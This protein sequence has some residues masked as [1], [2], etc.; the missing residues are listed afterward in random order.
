MTMAK[1]KNPAAAAVPA[2]AVRL[3]DR[4]QAGLRALRAVPLPD[5]RAV[6]IVHGLTSGGDFLDPVAAV[7]R[8]VADLLA[9]PDGDPRV[10]RFGGDLVFE[11]REDGDQRTLAPLRT[12]TTVERYAGGLLGN[13]LVC[14][15]QLK[16]GP[17]QFAAPPKALGVL[18]ADET[19]L[20]RLP[21]IDAYARRPVF[22]PD[23]VLLAPGYHLAHRILVHGPEVEPDLTPLPAGGRAIDRLPDRLRTLLADFCFKADADLVNAVG[24][25][26]TGLLAGHFVETGKPLALIDGNQPGVG[27]TLLVRVAGVLLDGRDPR[28][29]HFTANDEELAKR[30]CATL[31][32]GQQ[33]VL[34]IDNCKLA[35]GQ[36]VSSPALEANSM[37][38]EISLRILGVSANFVRPNDVL[39][40]LT[41]NSTRTSPDLVSRGIPIRLSYEGRPG[42]RR[43]SVADPVAYAR[44]HR[45]A[46]LGELAGFVERWAQAGRPPGTRPHRCHVWAQVIGGILAANGQPDFLANSAEA[47]D[48]FDAA[49]DELAA[50]A[51]AVLRTP[52]GPFAEAGTDLRG[53]AWKAGR[54]GALFAAAGI[55][56]GGFGGGPGAARGV[57]RWLSG[58]VGREALVARDGQTGTATLRAISGSA[59]E[60]RYGLEVRWSGPAGDDTLP[61]EPPPPEPPRAALAGGNSLDWGGDERTS[62]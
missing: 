46:I 39:W 28:L 52:D 7:V 47:A 26:L 14:E 13:V 33:S 22:S 8:Q 60:R 1:S 62:E 18:L 40:S 25:L 44:S 43:F 16:G 61:L 10:F 35:A 27:K 19:L 12:G 31:R 53:R 32:S 57:G 59:R 15:Q 4:L 50:L 38:A 24:W 56:V 17:V 37:A 42:D 34:G 20:A 49:A 21:R 2:A 41:M 58:W 29:I 3:A 54:W 23:F 9:P 51:E 11:L 55:E 36:P 45:V 6:P 30:L 5:T 48:E